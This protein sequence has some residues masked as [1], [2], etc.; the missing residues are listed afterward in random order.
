MITEDIVGWHRFYTT[1]RLIQYG[2]YLYLRWV[3]CLW[4]VRT[5]WELLT[6]CIPV[7]NPSP[8]CTPARELHK[9]GTGTPLFAENGEGCEWG[10]W[11]TMRASLG[12][13][14]STCLFW[15]KQVMTLALFKT[16]KLTFTD[17]DPSLFSIFPCSCPPF[18]FVGRSLSPRQALPV[19]LQATPHLLPSPFAHTVEMQ[20]VCDRISANC[21]WHMFS[22]KFSRHPETCMCQTSQ[23]G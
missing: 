12:Q 23:G 21:T 2:V 11:W 3:W 18:L 1:L 6:C 8:S 17:E 10:G 14:K 19:H 13:R 7:P 4:V 16:N 9:W 22:G 20:E 15:T 5:V